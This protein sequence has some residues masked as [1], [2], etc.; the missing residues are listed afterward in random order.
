MRMPSGVVNEALARESAASSG[1][2]HYIS[3]GALDG[4]AIGALLSGLILLVMVPRLIRRSR[5]DPAEGLWAYSPGRSRPRRDYFATPADGGQ[6]GAA[7][8]AARERAA[9]ADLDD[10]ADADTDAYPAAELTELDGA[11]REESAPDGLLSAGEPQPDGL[12]H[13]DVHLDLGL[14]D[15]PSLAANGG[16]HRSKHRSNKPAMP[17]W[18]LDVR[19]GRPRHAAGSAAASA[20]V[21]S[22]RE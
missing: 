16:S 12:R 22:I 10:F 19:R 11:V 6:F 2:M 17:L 13:D 7:L 21:A 9:A 1:I 14:D 4:F 15:R 5:S 3:P 18:R 8:L 20:Q